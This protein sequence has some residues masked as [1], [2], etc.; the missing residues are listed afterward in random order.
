RNSDGKILERSGSEEAVGFCDGATGVLARPAIISGY[1][2][3]FSRFRGSP[4]EIR[5]GHRTRSPRATADRVENLLFL[6]DSFWRSAEHECVPG[7]SGT[8]RSLAG[9]EPQGRGIRGSGGDG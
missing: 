5:A 6:L 8:S 3:H 9:A 2:D 7:V 1:G 4:R